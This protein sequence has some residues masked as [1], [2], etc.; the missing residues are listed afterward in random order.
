MNNNKH[1]SAAKKASKNKVTLRPL[2]S[3]RD[4]RLWEVLMTMKKRGV[5]KDQLPSY[6]KIAREI[7]SKGGPSLDNKQISK[8]LVRLK[9]FGYIKEFVVFAELAQVPVTA[10]VAA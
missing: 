3:D 8:S 4:K 7:E 5:I 6:K 10:W 1:T 9:S 2:Q